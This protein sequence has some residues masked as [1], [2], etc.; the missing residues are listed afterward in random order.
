MSNVKSSFYVL[1][2][3]LL[4]PIAFNYEKP[5]GFAL[6]PS[7]IP[8][9]APQAV[10]QALL[11]ASMPHATWSATLGSM[12]TVS[13]SQDSALATNE[14]LEAKSEVGQKIQ[15]PKYTCPESD[16]REQ[17]MFF[18]DHCG[19]AKDVTPWTDDGEPNAKCTGVSCRNFT[20]ASR[21]PRES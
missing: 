11:S 6:F 4:S 9:E 18:C 7:Q 10:N 21:K 19:G 16:G 15:K 2:L 8:L 1:P 12:P 3:I 5:L 20:C 13:A 14:A 17:D